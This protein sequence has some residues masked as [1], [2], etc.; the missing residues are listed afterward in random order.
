MP[1]QQRNILYVD[2][3]S[4]ISGDMFLAALLDA[5]LPLVYLE[6]NLQLLNL[7]N[8]RVNVTAKKVNSIQ[9]HHLEVQ[10]A[11]GQP[12]RPWHK[13]KE[14]ILASQLAD[15]IKARALAIFQ[16]L[17]QAEA[18]I[19]GCVAAD[20]HFHE[21]GGL[22]SIIDIVGAAIGLEYFKLARICCSPLPAPSGWVSCQHGKIPLPA[23]AV[24][25]LLKDIPVYGV[26]ISQ[27]LV[28]PTG[29]AIVKSLADDFGSQPA[30]IV[31]QIGY[32]AGTHQL[33][34]GQPNILRLL[35]GHAH[36]P[37][38][39][40]EVV[41]ITCNLDDWQT[42]GY[43][44]LCERLFTAGALDVAL[45]PAQM[46]KGRPGFI[47]QVIAAELSAQAL[48]DIVLSETS[49]IGL[50]FHNESRLT[51]PRQTGTIPSNYGPIRVK[52]IIGP[53]GM[54]L[55]PEYEDCKRLAGEYKVPLSEIYLEV[56]RQTIE[57]FKE[58]IK[59]GKNSTVPTPGYANT[60][61]QQTS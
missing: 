48:K 45:I 47:L 30:M 41:I 51:L 22:D 56:G 4:G 25:E 34:N 29:A 40:Q 6:E 43:P 3:F 32:G 44:Y 5:G 16:T 50:R 21:V 14:I 10:I 39:G 60:K 57:M 37:A 61:H 11:P 31:R 12:Q 15:T 24:C 42:E 58:D 33:D 38:E 7:N 19:H 49:A 1:S 27:E 20:V 36:T 8:F 9:V 53:T 59:Q 52:K 2:C 46:K 18:T 23:P 17:A 13:I 26:N 55:T 54:R 35:I 28:T